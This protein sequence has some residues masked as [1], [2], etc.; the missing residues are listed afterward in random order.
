[1]II[2]DAG[3][4]IALQSVDDAH[5]AAVLD[6]IRE[7][8]ERPL[9]AGGVTVAESLVHAARDGYVEDL[10]EEYEILGVASFDVPGEAAGTIA[11][12][13][14][15]TGLRL[16]DALVLYACE[17]ERAE[18]ATTDAALARA[19]HARRIRVHNLSEAAP[20]RV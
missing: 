20:T 19:A 4:L 9:A 16:P 5:H 2:L 10:L 1:M 8:R 18:L 6:F 12:V 11:R 7:H 17:R 14:A 13:R 15:E 3:V